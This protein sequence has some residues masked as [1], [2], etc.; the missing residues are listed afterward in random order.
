MVTRLGQIP[1]Q[2]AGAGGFSTRVVFF[3]VQVCDMILE[4]SL[5]QN[6]GYPVF[7]VFYQ[8]LNIY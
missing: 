4:L 7:G 2:E 8:L 6:L 3:P 5:D 1:T